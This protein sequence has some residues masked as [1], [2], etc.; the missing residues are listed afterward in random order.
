MNVYYQK[1]KFLQSISCAVILLFL[2]L[3]FNA[4]FMHNFQGVLESALK[5]NVW[6]VYLESA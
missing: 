2:V 3:L 4:V 5:Q 1:I 6:S